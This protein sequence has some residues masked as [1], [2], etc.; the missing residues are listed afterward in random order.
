MSKWSRKVSI[1]SFVGSDF[2]GK[3][4][5]LTRNSH[6][7]KH[8]I[9][10]RNRPTILKHRFVDESSSNRVF[11]YYDFNPESLD[12]VSERSLIELI[13]PYLKS[14]S[15]ILVADY[16]HGLMTEEIVKEICGS[17]QFL[18]VNTQANA[19]NR[20]FNTFSKYPRADLLSI[21][22]GELELELRK[23][24]IDFEKV[25]PNIIQERSCR[26]VIVTLGSRGLITFDSD[27][28]FSRSPAL[29]DKVIDR[30]GAG[31][32][33]LAMA[34]LL[35]SIAAPKEVIGLFSSVVAAFEVAQLGHKSSLSVVNLKRYV[36][37]LLG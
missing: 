16:G 28:T 10:V 5:E 6:Y 17:S 25:V 34:A 27:G 12:K 15:L 14:K 36:S 19:G 30:V 24:S 7:T 20:G 29:A 2:Q 3:F 9:E 18:A 21:N 32:S 31:D 13:G 11:E 33:V 8:L 35:S 26:N 1:V 37:G 22:G 4:S 23:R